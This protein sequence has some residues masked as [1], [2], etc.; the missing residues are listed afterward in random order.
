MNS[1]GLG[2]KMFILIFLLVILTGVFIAQNDS[3]G[4]EYF[5][6]FKMKLIGL[7]PELDLAKEDSGLDMT[8]IDIDALL[9]QDTEEESIIEEDDG[10]ENLDMI[11]SAVEDIG[12]ED[13]EEL[14]IASDDIQKELLRIKAEIDKIAEEIDRIEIEVQS[15]LTPQ[16]ITQNL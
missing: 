13:P 11:I 10:F 15:L 9:A 7:G 5:E 14:V 3:F 6:W 8:S 12:D 16:G 1:K 2:K 4:K